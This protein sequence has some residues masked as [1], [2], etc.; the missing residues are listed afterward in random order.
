M[1]STWL[2]ESRAG[3][4]NGPLCPPGLLFSQLDYSWFSQPF[5]LWPLFFFIVLCV[6][7]F[8]PLKYEA[9]NWSCSCRWG[10]ISVEQG[11]TIGFLV[12]D[13]RSLP[14]DAVY[15]LIPLGF[16]LSSVLIHNAEMVLAQSNIPSATRLS[17]VMATWSEVNSSSYSPPSCM[18]PFVQAT[19]F[20]S[21]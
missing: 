18:S 2:F 13:S 3:C 4:Y 5:P 1:F 9:P 21:V 16:C 14:F 6:L 15:F 10:L 11:V 8:I 20:S 12:L 17:L 7:W 19:P